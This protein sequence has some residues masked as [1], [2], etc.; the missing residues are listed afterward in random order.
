[1]RNR[2][3]EIKSKGF[4]IVQGRQDINYQQ[5]TGYMGMPSTEFE[6]IK[7][8][9]KILNDATFNLGDFKAINPRLANK[10]A[11]LEAINNYD[12]ATMREISEFFYKT[13]GIYSRLVRYMAFMYRYDWCL[14]PNAYGNEEI[15]KNKKTT[16]E[17]FNCLKMLDGF[18]VKKTLGDIALTVL[19]Q[20][21]YLDG[22]LVI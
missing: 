9:A 4:N 2:V 12:L 1:M 13:S 3:E 11:V 15:L 16:G 18:D 6:K 20:G 14:I 19:K 22:F 7:V 8:G 17:F 21:C 10:R 5:P